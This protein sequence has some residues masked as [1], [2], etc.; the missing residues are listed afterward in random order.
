MSLLKPANNE[1]AYLKMG[2]YGFAGGGKT[3][4]ASKIAIGLSKLLKD[5]RPVAFL[6]TETGSDFVIPLFKENKTKLLVSKSRAFID[7]LDVIDEAEKNCSVLIID[8]ITHFWN[9]LMEAYMKKRNVDRLIFKDWQPIKKEWRQYTD[10]YLKSK[11]HIIMNGRAGDSFGYV[12]NER[13]ELE[14]GKTDT[15]M[16]VEGE[17]GFEPSLLVE[18]QRLRSDINTVGSAYIHRG[19]VIKDRTNTING[20]YF[21]EPKFEDFLP[22]IKMLN[23][24]GSHV[25]ITEERDSQ[26][27]F[28]GERSNEEYFKRRDIVTEEIKDLF[29]EYMPEQTAEAKAEKIQILKAVFGTS[30]WTAICAMKLN[31]LEQGKLNLT[32]KLISTIKNRQEQTATEDTPKKKKSKGE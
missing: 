5:D 25:A 21:D 24:G 14:M 26:A 16:K 27:M 10:R 12:A 2:I 20:R 13:G 23:I 18:L 19:W 4:T 11:L 15:K 17:T 1:S 28:D 32:D 7:L 9:E 29:T 30:S 3:F 8:S 31:A 6:D 22:H